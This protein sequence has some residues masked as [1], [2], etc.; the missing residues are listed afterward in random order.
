METFW[1]YL[2][3]CT[4]TLWLSSHTKADI[5]HF[6]RITLVYL[7]RLLD[8]LPPSFLYLSYLQ[9]FF[10]SLCDHIARKR[11]MRQEDTIVN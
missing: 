2:L 10:F 8:I 6:L 9:Y 4:S 11:E 5:L 1:D 7:V 3:D